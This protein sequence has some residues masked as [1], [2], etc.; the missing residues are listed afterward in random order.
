MKVR[1]GML[2]VDAATRFGAST[3]LT[4]NG[5]HTTFSELDRA[6]NRAGNRL[7]HVGLA[8]GEV[9]GVLMYNRP[10]AVHLWLGLERAGLLRVTL[11][12]H[13]EMQTHVDLLT[14]LGSSTIVFDSRFTSLVESCL[15]QL[16][17]FRLIAVGTDAPDWATP[18]DEVTSAGDDEP[19]Y[20][21]VDEDTPAFIQ[22]TTGTTGTP[23]PWIVTHRSWAAVVNQNLLH[24][25][26]FDGDLSSLGPNDVWMHVHALQWA[27]GFQ[28][29]Y[30]PML[31][32][33]RTVLV[34]DSD[35]DPEA[36]LDEILAEG[37]TGL[38]LPAPMLTPILDVIEAR[39]RVEHT[40]TRLVIFFASPE[41]LDR[42]T[43]LLGPVWC[44]GF[45]STEQGAV[46]TRLLPSEVTD[47]PVRLG[48]VGRAASPF[49]E[50]AIFND[51]GERASTGQLGE[52][53]VRSAMSTST[54]WNMPDRTER[55]FHPGDWFR[56]EDIGYLDEDGFLYYVD[57]AV[58]SIATPEGTVYPHS[59][60]NAVLR[61]RSVANCG[62]V[63]DG[64][65]GVIAAVALKPGTANTVELREEIRAAAAPGLKE[66]EVP[67]IL[68]MDELPTVLGGA[69]VQRGLLREQVAGTR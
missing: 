25:D 1:A 35:F 52:I 45:G 8:E 57:R 18:W 15:D 63:S 4:F 14:H 68:V 43:K 49:F 17:G 19:W 55:V 7:R 24:L 66:H 61:H 48:S 10:E 5:E 40:I 53:V 29:L 37:V 32:G 16:E 30:P 38:L 65:G 54:Y 46:T 11:H 6:A 2:A 41:L 47:H 21:E 60:E 58:D 44:H 31:R 56:P 22:P 50:V 39:G 51:R 59:V 23:K 13:F 33:A 64:N 26:T 28:L 62:V 9:V 67:R 20:L 27:T 12:S 69:K 3:A 36:V 34:D 42:V